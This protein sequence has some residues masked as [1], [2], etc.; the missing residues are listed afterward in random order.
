MA[1]ILALVALTILGLVVTIVVCVWGFALGTLL[2]VIIAE[3]DGLDRSIA[4]HLCFNSSNSSRTAL[5][6]SRR[7]STSAFKT[8]MPSTMALQTLQT[9]AR[10]V[11]NDPC[12]APPC[13]RSCGTG[14]LEPFA[15]FPRP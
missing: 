2:C 9:L 8:T 7:A 1:V 11:P 14:D 15:P 12:L 3:W 6:S 4:V 5:S 10:F 13:R